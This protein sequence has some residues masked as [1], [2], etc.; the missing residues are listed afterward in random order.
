MAFIQIFAL[1]VLQGFNGF[2]S[3]TKLNQFNL[4]SH[5]DL[6]EDPGLTIDVTAHFSLFIDSGRSYWPVI[7]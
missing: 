5:F 7:Y 4:A 1:V 3:I 2:L 6:L